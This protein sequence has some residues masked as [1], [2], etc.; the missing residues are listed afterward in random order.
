MG[1]AGQEPA[2]EFTDQRTGDVKQA[3]TMKWD[4]GPAN[5]GDATS[6]SVG[7]TLLDLGRVRG[8]ATGE[9]GGERS[10]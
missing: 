9:R 7:L 8:V 2:C 5:R 4:T 10:Q 3:L 1:P 6:V